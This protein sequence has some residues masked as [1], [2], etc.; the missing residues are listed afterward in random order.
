MIRD[1]GLDAL[2]P[3]AAALVRSVMAEQARLTQELSRLASVVHNLSVQ[4][5]MPEVGTH[6]CPAW[7]CSRWVTPVDGRWPGHEI[8]AGPPGRRN[9]PF[10]RLSGQPV[11]MTAMAVTS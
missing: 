1:E 7:G 9:G 10:C 2:D 4:Q 3:A 11:P 5:Q 8:V 6:R